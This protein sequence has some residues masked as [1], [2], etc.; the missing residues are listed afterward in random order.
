MIAARTLASVPFVVSPSIQVATIRAPASAAKSD[1]F[2]D[3][4]T[5]D[6]GV[7]AVDDERGGED[8]DGRAEREQ[9]EDLASIAAVR[10]DVR[11]A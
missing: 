3:V 2:W 10:D 11:I 6:E 1:A 5:L 4:A 9:G 8:D 7:A